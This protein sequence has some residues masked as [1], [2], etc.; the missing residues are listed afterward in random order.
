MHTLSRKTKMPDSNV[1]LLF[2]TWPAARR[3]ENLDLE[4]V[5]RDDTSADLQAAK[6]RSALSDREN[7]QTWADLHGA[8]EGRTPVAMFWY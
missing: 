8:E 5:S 6:E 7:I 3:R 1:G 4:R 2:R